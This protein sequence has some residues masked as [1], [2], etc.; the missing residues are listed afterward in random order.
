MYTFGPG[1]TPF[2]VLVNLHDG[3]TV[4]IAEAEAD[5]LYDQLWLLVP[6][7]GAVTAAAKIKHALAYRSIRSIHSI[8]A[9]TVDLDHFESEAFT[10]ALERR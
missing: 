3:A 5:K 9:P 1:N 10:A 7:R 4:E 2:G 8:G 6:R